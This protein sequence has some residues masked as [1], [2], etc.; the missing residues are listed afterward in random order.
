MEINLNITFKDHAGAVVKTQE[1]DKL[2]D[3]TMK[4]LLI[5]SL[6]HLT[7]TNP[8]TGEREQLDPSE[9]YKRGKMIHD[10]IAAKDKMK[11][12]SEDVAMIKPLITK[13][14]YSPSIVFQ[15]FQVLD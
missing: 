5:A 15:A 10:I 3:L 2:V 14:G 1:G 7:V 4:S 11:L 9:S 8:Y 6:N 12:S 13:A